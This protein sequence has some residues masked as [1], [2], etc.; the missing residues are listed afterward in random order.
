MQSGGLKGGPPLEVGADHAEL[1]GR[2]RKKYAAAPFLAHRDR[3]CEP[4]V[5]VLGLQAERSFHGDLEALARYLGTGGPQFEELVQGI[6][7]GCAQLQLRVAAVGVA[8]ETGRDGGVAADQ[9]ALQDDL[10]GILSIEGRLFG[11]SPRLQRRC[12]LCVYLHPSIALRHRRQTA[13]RADPRD[14]RAPV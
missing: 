12:A 6:T 8:G 4:C 2:F 13:R 11:S 10:V 5:G 1:P 14:R 3:Q 7:V 9:A